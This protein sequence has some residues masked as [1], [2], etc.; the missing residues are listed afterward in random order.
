LSPQQRSFF[1]VVR[2]GR[3]VGRVVRIMAAGRQVLSRCS[4]G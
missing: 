3:I 1:D 4:P 2:L